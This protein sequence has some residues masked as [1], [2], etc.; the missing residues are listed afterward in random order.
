MTLDSPARRGESAEPFEARVK[1]RLRLFACCLLL[2]AIAYN[3]ATEKIISETKI[4]MAVNPLGFLGRA[5][6]LWDG[7]YFGHLQ[8]QAYGYLFPMG[9][10]YSLWLQ[11]GMPAWSVQRLWMSL[12]LCAAFLGVVQ[13]ARA[14]GIGG[15][16]TRCLAG[17]AYALAPHAQALIGINSSEFLPSAILP[18][19]LLPL[20]KGAKGE[21]SPRRAAALS[22]V[23]FVF[24]GGV[25]AAAELA[26]LVVPLLYL[27]TRAR[28]PRKRRLIAWWLALVAAVSLWWLIP[29]LLLGKFTFSFLPYIESAS[30]TTSVTSLTNVLRGTSSWLSF[31]SVDG[32]VW[33]PS[34]NEQS[35]RAWLIVVTAAVAGMGIAGLARR[36]LP[37]RT[38]LLVSAVAGVAIVTT[39]H[40]SAIAGP[41]A[42]LMVELMNG[43]L[44]AFRNVHKFD[45]LIR[46][47]LALGVAGLLVGVR[48]RWRTPLVAA[49]AGLLTLSCLPILS[50]GL[51]PAGGFSSVPDY[52]KQAISW[53]DRHTGDGMVLAVPGSKRGEYLWGRPLDEPL[54]PLLQSR[55][56]THTIVPWG[57]AGVSRLTA[58]I[59]DRFAAG[60]GSAGLTSTLRRMG[61]KYLVVRNDLDR[62][63]IGTAWPIRVHQAIADSPGIRPVQ[64]FGALVGELQYGKAAGWLDQPYSAVEVYEVTDP[65]PLVGTLD[66]R[67]PLRVTGAPEALLTL[68]EQGLLT[69]DRPVLVGDDPGAAKIPRYDTVVT[70]TLRRREVAFSDLRQSS[71]ATMTQD[72]KF[73]GTATIN[74]VVEPAWRRYVSSAIYFQIQGVK[75]STSESDVS[76]MP[77][78]REQGHQPYA[79]LDGDEKTSWR[80]SGW[81][82]AVGEWL[83]VDLQEPMEIPYVRISFENS[84]I[85]PPPT[86][87]LVETDAGT[88]RQAVRPTGDAQD[89]A[90][91]A[92]KIR[93]LRVKVTRT[94]YAPKSELGSRVGIKELVIPGVQPG[95]SVVVPDPDQGDEQATVSL[96]R[97][98]DVAGCVKGSLSWSCSNRQEIL[99]D[100]GHGFDRTF[101][102][103]AQGDT[104]ISGQ[105]VLTDRETIER[106]TTLPRD[107][108]TVKASSTAVADGAAGGRWA[109]DGDPKTVWFADPL[110]ARPT[111][112]V[113]LAKQKELAGLALLFPDSYLGAPP[114]RVTVRSEGGTREAWV[115]EGGRISFPPM[116][117]KK[118]TLEFT[119]LGNRPVEVAE[120]SIPGVRKLGALGGFQ[121][122]LPCGYGPTLEVNGTSV[123]TKI[124]GGT[125]ND[126]VTGKPLAF[127][128]CQG[129]YLVTGPNRLSVP[130]LDPYRIDSAVVGRVPGAATQQATKLEPVKVGAWGEGERTVE[131]KAERDSYLVVNE[132]FNAGWQATLEGVPL[133]AV[134]LD[135]WRQAWVLPEGAAGKVT[136]T[137]TPDAPYRAT[138]AGGGV[139]V[140]F[141]VALA[142]GRRHRRRLAP[143]VPAKL[144]VRSVSVLAALF[145]FWVGGPAGLVVVTGCFLVGAAVRPQRLAAHVRP[146][147]RRRL[148]LWLL[149]G[150]VA[151]GLFLLAALSLAV[152]SF[153]DG[154]AVTD[155]LSQ[156]LC[157]PVL[158]YL[159]SWVP[160]DR[161]PLHVQPVV[162]APALASGGVR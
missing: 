152:G 120:I 103:S 94:A 1:H 133:A 154:R 43:P 118:I 101:V 77:N 23:A 29:L 100:D 162:A 66:A 110:Q 55:W 107:P 53:L 102:S 49:G 10:F 87:V 146:K 157:L 105:A 67:R 59:D 74:D 131:V 127:E 33:L 79:A 20:V 12:V 113:E 129:A 142:F 4:D 54:Q 69:D 138:L 19:I 116:R 11:L 32:Q 47:P 143:A 8:N 124:V 7:N 71:S 58:A 50:A 119:T 38:F 132:N 48:V 98:G 16:A 52:W 35:A 144:G 9:P 27:L 140:L 159:L 153:L 21:L 89:L 70:D 161:E 28:G 64:G 56:A 36:G 83:Q 68:A 150:P 17:F 40:I 93:K 63:T 22:A 6:H 106:L 160:A 114:V 84:V 122:R 134:R 15:S 14:M 147:R 90:L 37:E 137:Y 111:L 123:N 62:N 73:R 136:M 45:A 112:T 95:R 115:G 125:L 18:W 30:A 135:G 65:A 75:A 31:L 96:S 128:A 39:G 117:A 76:A 42:G 60:K 5:L 104:L 41:Q 85:G 46:L 126:V 44:A 86:E 149:S 156:L 91:P 141:V 99:G 82:G 61:V 78:T 97:Q 139:L 2:A 13:L 158:G 109:F 34:A 26:V 3:T 130:P 151:I 51:A 88:V 57:S 155:L 121:L 81:N 145:G 24:C 72:E 108:L 25:N 80:S 92:G 148:L